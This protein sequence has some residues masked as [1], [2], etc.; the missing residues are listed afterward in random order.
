MSL[1]H[2]DGQ[3]CGLCEAKL[4]DAHPR[5][6]TW[7]RDLKARYLNVHISCSHRNQVEQEQAF[8]DGKTKAHFPFSPHNVMPAMALDLFQIDEDGVGRWS[9]MFMAKINKENKESGEPII[10]GIEF[11][12]LGDSC[13]FQ[14]NLK[15][16][17]LGA[18]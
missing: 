12:N 16:D 7:F 1:H 3:K 15:V 5:I 17:P 8:L 18:A 13:H 9:P 14:L 4:L 2:E 11:K 10:C 6:A